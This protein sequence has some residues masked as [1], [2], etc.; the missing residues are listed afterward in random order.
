MEPACF[1][2]PGQKEAYYLDDDGDMAAQ[3]IV[4]SNMNHD[5]IDVNIFNSALYWTNKDNPKGLSKKAN[6]DSDGTLEHFG[7]TV[8]GEPTKIEIACP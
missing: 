1:H 5:L 7:V 4:N 8:F 2:H 6:Y 3:R